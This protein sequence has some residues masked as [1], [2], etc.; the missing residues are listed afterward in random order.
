MTQKPEQGIVVAVDG[1]A[2]STAAVVWAAHD[3]DMRGLPLKVVHVVA[4][5][6]Y[7]AQGW[8]PFPTAVYSQI[9]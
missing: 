1:S 4:P 9:Q 6:T 7:V 2:S 8:S 3:A 5:L